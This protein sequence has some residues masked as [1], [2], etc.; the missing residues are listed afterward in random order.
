[1][2]SLIW[3]CLIAT[4]FTEQRPEIFYGEF[5]RDGKQVNVLSP[6][7]NQNQPKTC[8]ASFAFA[9][10][11]AMSD[12]FNKI[13]DVEF[14][15][16]TLS[17]QMMML[18]SVAEADRK[19][20]YRA[21]A[22]DTNLVALLDSLKSKG[23]A[24]ESCNN[25]YADTT[26]KCDKYALCKDC[27]NGE[28]LTNETTCFPRDYH[29]FKLKD[30]AKIESSKEGDERLDDL[31]NQV[32]QKLTDWGPLVCNISHGKSLFRYRTG[33]IL[34]YEPSS[35]ELEYNTWVSIVGYIR[36]PVL[37]TQ[38]LWVVRLSFGDNVGYYGYIYL[39]AEP[40]QNPL[41]LLDNCYAIQ[42]EPK[43]ELVKNSDKELGLINT[44]FDIRQSRFGHLKTNTP[45]ITA[46]NGQA[47]EDTDT[48]IFWG[49]V[50]GVNYLTWMKNQHIP[51]YCGS[52]WA[53]AA[54]SVLS[55]RLNIQFATKQYQTFPRHIFSV[56][57]LINCRKA[58][59]CLGG[60]SGLA[61]EL[62]KTWK[63]PTQT[64]RVYESKNPTLFN[65]EGLSRCYNADKD[66]A[67]NVELFNGIKV[68]EW[69]RIRGEAAIKLH[70]KDGPV[71]CFFEVT[72]NFDDYKA[73]EDHLVIYDEKKNLFFVNHVVGIVGWDQDEKGGYWIVRNS[74]GSEF[75]Y[76]GMFYMRMGNILGLESMCQVPTKFEFVQ[77]NQKD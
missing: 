23:I 32:H 17:P 66:E 72:P 20:D 9:L 54:T 71:A 2:R 42:V 47:E 30:H 22:S 8:G 69:K 53:Q 5:Q 19:C 36:D 65:C 1:M 59:T 58:G 21:N 24:D 14:P 35:E 57:A 11:S 13:K 48:P 68:N 16:V 37:G 49:N 62:A 10:T 67:W 45:K 64:C 77:W 18:C 55:D 56:Q 41:G 33:T 61:F 73:A 76:N 75:G 40:L 74:W 6:V 38:D 15:E 46:D 7:R 43:V 28:V 31:A 29:S 50:D 12:Q 70:L 27:Q 39:K 52:C 60:D 4:T 51:T 34:P 25:W 44:P 3:I 63:I 26:S